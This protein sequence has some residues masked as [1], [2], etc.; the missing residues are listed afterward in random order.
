VGSN[1]TPSATLFA[2]PDSR[3]A[4]RPGRAMIWARECEPTVHACADAHASLRWGFESHPLRHFICASRL[5]FREPAGTRDDLGAGM[6]PYESRM[7]G[8]ATQ[9]NFESNGV[10][11]TLDTQFLVVGCFAIC[12]NHV[13]YRQFLHTSCAQVFHIVF[14]RGGIICVQAANRSAWRNAELRAGFPACGWPV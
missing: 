12:A 4:S 11:A 10:C 5:A 9:P 14:R 6:R 13:A 8:H 2:R 1:P 3:S 7:H